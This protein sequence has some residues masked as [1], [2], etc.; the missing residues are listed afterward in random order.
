MLQRVSPTVRRAKLRVLPEDWTAA[1]DNKLRDTK[2]KYAKIAALS[3]KMQI[4]ESAL[5]T[6]WHRLRSES[7]KSKAPKKQSV[8]KADMKPVPGY[9]TG[10]DAAKAVLKRPQHVQLADAILSRPGCSPSDL[11]ALLGVK[12]QYA[13]RYVSE[14]RERLMRVGWTISTYSKGQGYKFERKA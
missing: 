3:D 7:V 13:A 10:L 1:D 11:G 5:I 2:G 12:E 4:A 6:R 9:D 8:D 14:M